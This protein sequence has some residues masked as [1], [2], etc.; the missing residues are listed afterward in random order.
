MTAGGKG[1]ARRRENAALVE[2]NWDAVFGKRVTGLTTITELAEM[3]GHGRAVEAS[4]S[5]PD[6]VGSIPT[7]PANCDGCQVAVYIDD[8]T[9]QT[10]TAEWWPGD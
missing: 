9:G 10:V 8:A 1:H 5:N 2:S 3:M 7:A 6:K 4:G